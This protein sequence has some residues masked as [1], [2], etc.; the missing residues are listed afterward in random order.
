M[1]HMCP[2]MMGPLLEDGCIT[3]IAEFKKQKILVCGTDCS[4]LLISKLPEVT[5]KVI[6]KIK[7]HKK[8]EYREAAEIKILDGVIKADYI[9]E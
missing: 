7:E 3:K 8:F 4:G 9:K 2:I 1:K 6:P 5:S